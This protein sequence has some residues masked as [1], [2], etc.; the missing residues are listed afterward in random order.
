MNAKDVNICGLNVDEFY[1]TFM[2]KNVK[3]IQDTL[4]HECT[5]K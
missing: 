1:E 5:I 4:G 3:E 2:C